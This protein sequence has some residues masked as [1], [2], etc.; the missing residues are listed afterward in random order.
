MTDGRDAEKRAKEV[1]ETAGFQV[2]LP[3]L[4][5]FREQDVFGLFDLLC[6]QSG[7]LVGVQVKASRHARGINDWMQQARDY[8]ETV[9]GM[10][11]E[12]LHSSSDGWRLAR[13]RAV[14]WKWVYD[15]REHGEQAREA[16]LDTLKR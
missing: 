8:Q 12:F 10:Y 6:Y 5:K 15:G 14:D 11:V 7:T 13:P 16:L 2:Y 3:P 4:A 1:Y 9:D